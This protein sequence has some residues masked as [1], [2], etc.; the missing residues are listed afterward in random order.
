MKKLILLFLLSVSFVSHANGDPLDN[1]GNRC[2]YNEVLYYAQTVDHKK[3]VLVC[4]KNTTITYLFGKVGQKPDIELKMPVKMVSDLIT[5]SS[6]VS[7]EYLMIRNGNIIYQV[8]HMTDLLSGADIES[9]SVIKYGQGKFAEI[10]LDPDTAVN[11][12][13]DRF[14]KG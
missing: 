14:Y 12:I 8:G 13:R 4:Q 2:E 3:E 10:L 9:V 5:D 1:V 7:S 6:T 11:A